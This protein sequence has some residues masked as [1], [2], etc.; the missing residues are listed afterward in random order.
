MTTLIFDVFLDDIDR[1]TSAG[2][3]KVAPAPKNIFPVTILDFR[4]LLAQQS[5]G[6]SFEA[7]D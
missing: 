5:A 2:G 7:V 6:N 3:G 4:M 1:G